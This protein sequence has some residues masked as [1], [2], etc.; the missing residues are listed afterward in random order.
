ML[1]IENLEVAYGQMEVIKKV[2]LEVKKGEL[3]CVIG[4]NGAGKTT[5]IKTIMGLKEALSGRIL[6]EGK[7]I[8]RYSQILKWF[9]RCFPAW[10]SVA[11]SWHGP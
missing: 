7:D 11:A 9:T 4:P 2:S 8:R 1:K 3:V 6:L 5:L 10:E